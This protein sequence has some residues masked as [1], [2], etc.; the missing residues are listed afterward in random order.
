MEKIFTLTSSPGGCWYYRIKK[1][2]EDFAVF[3]SP[4][5]FESDWLP[6]ELKKKP[7]LICRTNHAKAVLNTID[8]FFPGCK[9]VLD[10]DD[11]V[12]DVSPYNANYE[13]Y[14]EKEVKHGDKWLWKD[15]ETINIK[16]NKIELDYIRKFI[17]RA[18]VLT[19]ST[20]LLAKRFDHPNIYINYNGIDFKEWH[21]VNIKREK[22]EFRLG[23]SGSPSHYIDW[24]MIQDQLA[25]VMQKY[26]DVKLVLAGAKFDGTVKNIAPERIEHWDWVL[27]EAHPYRSVL[28]DLDLA[29]IPLA[30]DRFN[31][32]RSCIKWYEF[33]ALGYP[34]IASDTAP[35]STEM[36]KEQLF[37]NLAETFAKFYNNENLRQE[38]ADNQYQWVRKNRDQ[39]NLSKK[40]LSYIQPS[41]E[42]E[43]K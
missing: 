4:G 13:F 16:A 37:T 38:V 6:G 25:E 15:G 24:A 22:K 31:S 5:D 19:V 14:G 42:A 36:P 41:S 35:Y 1:P 18:D 33:S 11:D 27:P 30:D 40:L 43:T 9:I 21:R 32:C 34:T 29:I 39:K 20:P 26:P 8:R 23:W 2:Y 12:F 7:T 28:L 3:L 17:K 10:L